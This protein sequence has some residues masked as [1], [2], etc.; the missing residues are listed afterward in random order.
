MKHFKRYAF[1]VLWVALGSLLVLNILAYTHA[2]SMMT[3]AGEG[4]RTPPPDQLS[5]P[6]KFGVL[7]TGVRLP[8]PRNERTPEDLSLAF[9]RRVIQS[10]EDVS[11]E[12]W[13][14]HHE[15]PRA[16]V[17]M[18]H[19]YGVS[20]STMLSAARGF[21]R[22]R[23]TTF[24]VDFRGAGGSS[25]ETTTMG[26]HEADDVA[27]VYNYAENAYPEEPLILYGQSMGA[28]AALRAV[29]VHNVHPDAI[30]LE[31]V[32]DRLLTTVQNRFDMV[33]FPRFPASHLL[34]FWGGVQTGIDAFDLNPVEYASSVTCPALIMHGGEDRRALPSQAES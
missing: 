30:I 9:E 31:A 4:K 17:I 1:G 8:H 23:C 34:L 20:K 10:T 19:G 24:L 29:A 33:G 21:H 6:Q 18:F 7:L 11:L 5:F 22:M 25:G 28:A 32:Y 2:R 13:E 14:I 27:A 3:F 26:F 12:V 16:V 15:E